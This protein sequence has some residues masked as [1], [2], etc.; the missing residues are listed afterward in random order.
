MPDMRNAIATQAFAAILTAACVVARRWYDKERWTWA[1]TAPPRVRR[2][3][4]HLTRLALQ[5]YKFI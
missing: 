3:A 2:A 1:Q 5:G 4:V